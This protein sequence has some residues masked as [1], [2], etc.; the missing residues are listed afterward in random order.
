[1]I[2][3]F[4]FYIHTGV[5]L[6]FGVFLSAAF[7][8]T[9][10]SRKNFV[11]LLG[12]SMFSGILQLA[13]YLPFGED[14]VRKIYPLITHLPL[15]IL[16]CRVYRQKFLVAATAIG[17]AYLCCHPSKWFGILTF[18]ITENL[19][20]EYMMRIFILVVV[21]AMSLLFLAPYLS[22]FNGNDR[23]SFY[24]FSLVPAVYYVYDYIVVVY[25]DF[26]SSNNLIVL[27]FLP[28]F[29]CIVF[30]LFCILYCKEWEKKAD[31]ERKEQIIRI[32]M[33]QQLK[34]FESVKSSEREIKILRH[35][36]R[37]L[38]NSVSTCIENDD[39]ETARKLI[40][41]YTDS[42][43]ATSVQKYCS[44]IVLNYIISDFSAKCKKYDVEFL[45]QIELGRITCD[46]VMFSTIVSNALDNALN[47]QKKLPSEE[48]NIRLM[49]KNHGNKILLS[50]KNPYQNPPIMADGIP[51]ST[52]K[53]HGYGTKSIVYLTERLG[54]NCQ[55]TI[56]EDSFVLRIVIP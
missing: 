27:E 24:I 15:L 11:I 54:G 31:A 48:R 16:L 38:L 7:A 1:M 10:F 56:E 39:K 8:G 40:S 33:E 45:Y 43:E 20:A 9:R 30:M 51:I 17:V 14:A 35:D 41:A 12:F 5:L 6:L 44:N 13:V 18:A 37:L 32:A 47:A 53:G 34:E 23:F 28:F 50:V 25:T 29:L 46:E 52:K 2:Q 3:N 36:M 42:V 4:L 19:T 55:F 21:A 26:G 22:N 49:L